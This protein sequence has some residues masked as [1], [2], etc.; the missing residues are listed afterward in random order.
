MVLL[1]P[2]LETRPQHTASPHSGTPTE[3][4]PQGVPVG[5]GSDVLQGPG[6]DV[7]SLDSSF[8]APP[9]G[10][11]VCKAGLILLQESVVRGGLTDG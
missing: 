9:L 8:P 2:S 6:A 10:T 4:C 7:C 5:S 1:Y 11:S 3:T